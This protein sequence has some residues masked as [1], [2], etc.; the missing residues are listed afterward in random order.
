MSYDQDAMD[1]VAVRQCVA[2]EKVVLALAAIEQN[3][4]SLD[5]HG[6]AVYMVPRA[7]ME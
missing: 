7:K 3:L 6:I 1:A 4:R 5:E 2:L